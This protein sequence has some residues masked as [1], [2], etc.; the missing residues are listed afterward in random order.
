MALKI[1][2]ILHAGYSFE[3]ERTHILF[4]PIFETPFSRNCFAF[5][6][7]VFDTAQIRELKFDA[8]FISH[9]HDDHCSLESLTFLNRETPIYIFCVHDEM[10]EII[11]SLGFLNVISLQ[12]NETVETGSIRVTTVPALDVDVD[13]IFHIQT[14]G[15]NILNVVD[16]WLDHDTVSKLK[17][18]GPWDMILW[19]FQTMREIE[20]LSPSR[21]KNQPIEFPSEWLEQIQSLN[22]KI[23]V[24]S[25]CQFIHESWSWYNHAFFPITYRHFENEIKAILPQTQVLRLNPGVSITLDKHSFHMSSRLGWVKPIGNQD[26]DYEYH[27]EAVIPTTAQIASQ[28]APINKSEIDRVF[29][30]CMDELPNVYAHLYPH[31]HDYDVG[32]FGQPRLWRLNLYDHLGRVRT[33]DYKVKGRRITRIDTHTDKVAW[34]TEVPVAKL[35]AAL[36][37]GESLTSMYMRIND[38]QFE[39]DCETDLANADVFEDPLVRCLFNG[40]FGAYQKA[41]LKRIFGKA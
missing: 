5:P 16:S 25:S 37:W 4:D 40:V 33:L 23:I 28:I 20:V 32:Y 19:P 39:P 3:C 36:E 13:S 24:P 27:P 29:T 11:R 2:R 8:V 18:R 6:N 22:P 12:L 9:Y 14:D 26:V 10:L 1:S 35:Y 38:I 7:V 41:Q 30:Y 34:L 21:F 17:Q 15:L 31:D